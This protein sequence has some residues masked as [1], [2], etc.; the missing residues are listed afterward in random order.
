MAKK[1]T[2][3]WEVQCASMGCLAS[4]QK[5]CRFVSDH[6]RD[7]VAKPT[8]RTRAERKRNRREEGGKIWSR[9]H[10]TA[11]RRDIAVQQASPR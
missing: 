10:D 11:I 3:S 5:E 1:R 6:D 9:V 4:R 8:T 2:E 7:G